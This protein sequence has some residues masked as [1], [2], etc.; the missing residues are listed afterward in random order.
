MPFADV[1]CESESSQN[2]WS[3][4][5]ALFSNGSL[6]RDDVFLTIVVEHDLEPSN[7]LGSTLSQST[8][9]HFDLALMAWPNF[10]PDG[11][12][13]AQLFRE[14][15]SKLRDIVH[16]AEQCLT[17]VGVCHVNASSLM[18]IA[19]WRDEERPEVI[20]VEAHP[21]LPQVD[22]LSE[23]QALGITMMAMSP[24]ATPAR[25]VTH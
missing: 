5:E 2:F 14:R 9:D 18:E 3:A 11:G 25:Y 12:F 4:L 7:K 22:M 23:C 8:V 24:F 17:A 10:G 20:C 21:E 6:S 16:N 19:K 1:G 15:Y 13:H